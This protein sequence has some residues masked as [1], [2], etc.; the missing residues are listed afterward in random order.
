M[1]MAYETI[2]WQMYE[3]EHREKSADWYWALGI[4]AIAAAVAAIFLGNILFAIILLLGAFTLGM[5]GNSKP[6]VYTYQLSRR[7]IQ[8]EKNLYTFETLDSFWIEEFEDRP[9]RILV[10]SQKF[11]MPYIIMPL[12]PDMDPEEIRHFFLDHGLPEIEHHES[13][14]HQ[15]FEYLGF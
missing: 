1:A 8:V 13:F 10:K 6:K 3:F 12:S 9:H 5:H 7:G 14:L 11:F 15:L 4:I 2:A